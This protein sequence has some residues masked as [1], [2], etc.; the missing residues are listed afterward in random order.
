MSTWMEFVEDR[1]IVDLIATVTPKKACPMKVCQTILNQFDIM[2][3]HRNISRTRMVEILMYKELLEYGYDIKKDYGKWIFDGSVKAR[4]SGSKMN[5]PGDIL[6]V[7]V[8][9]ED[10]LPM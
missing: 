1:K 6:K 8:N 4:E 5:K 3:K 2:A 9:I 7:H 10:E